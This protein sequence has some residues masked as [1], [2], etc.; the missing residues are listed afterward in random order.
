MSLLFEEPW[1][2]HGTTVRGW[3]NYFF[4]KTDPS[5]KFD[6]CVDVQFK[7]SRRF[8]FQQIAS[9]RAI[10]HQSDQIFGHLQKWKLTQW[11]KKLPKQ[12]QHFAKYKVKVEKKSHRLEHF[13]KVTKIRQIWSHCHHRD[14]HK[15]LE[16]YGLYDLPSYLGSE[17]KSQI[18]LH[19]LWLIANLRY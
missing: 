13:T 9:L 2:W 11:H 18:L 6:Q 7:R 5:R 3:P 16:R 19:V 10:H 1:T 4:K 14:K 12:V 8:S 17:I 15:L